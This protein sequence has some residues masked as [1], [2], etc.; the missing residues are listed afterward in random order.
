MD[1]NVDVILRGFL[2]D[3]LKILPKVKGDNS[4]KIILI[5]AN[6]LSIILSDEKLYSIDGKEGKKN[7]EIRN[8]IKKLI[9]IFGNLIQDNEL[10]EEILSLLSLIVERDENYILLY[11]NT[12]VIDFIFDI[13]MK[14]EYY[15]NLNILKILIILM[16]SK[17]IEFKD[18]INMNFI[19]R[20]NVLIERSTKNYTSSNNE[21][22]DN[23]ESIYV[24]YVF[25]LLYEMIIKLL[26]YKKTKYP[27]ITNVAQFQKD[28]SSKVEPI[29]RNFDLFIKMMGNNKNV[30]LQEISCLCLIFILQT[31][32]GVKFENMKFELKF[33]ANDIPNL[34]KG[35]ELSCYKIHKKMIHIFRWII[36]FQ[37][38]ANK[39]LKP[40]ISYLITY[41]ENI[42]NTSADPNVI[43]NAQSFLENEIKKLKK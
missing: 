9:P 26:D 24:D 21:E 17:N 40:Y 43:S 10:T 27:K 14:K 25:Q 31:F 18:I 15:N 3:I 5:T 23:D 19:E 38:D 32:P 22:N 37:N 8:L 30:N 7:S 12:G 20:I 28:F 6:I 35:L 42:C 16:E 4:S 11:Q 33:K 29:V 2:I 36:Q 13:M 1:Q 39:I 34:L 41:L